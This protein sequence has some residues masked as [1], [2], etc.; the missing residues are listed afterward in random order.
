M[1]DRLGNELNIGEI[2]T[3]FDKESKQFVGKLEKVGRKYLTV[4]YSEGK[5]KLLPEKVQVYKNGEVN[6]WTGK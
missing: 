3:W 4:K 5:T 2:I 6:I 1:L